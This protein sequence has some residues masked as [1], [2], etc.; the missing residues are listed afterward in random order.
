MGAFF[1][2]H[3]VR[4]QSPS[5]VA[6]AVAKVVSGKAYVSPESGGWVSVYAEDSET[7]AEDILT[8]IAEGLSKLLKT[9]VIGFLVHDSDIAAYWLYQSGKLADQFNSCPDYFG[10]DIDEKTRQSLRGNTD[11]L[12]PLCL[13][14]TPRDNLDSLLHSSDDEP[15]FA[16][17]ILSE[18]AAFLGIDAQRITAGHGIFE[19]EGVELFEDADQFI[20]VSGKA[21][22]KKRNSKTNEAPEKVPDPAVVSIVLLTM[23]WIANVEGLKEYEFA[24]LGGISRQQLESSFENAAKE[25][26]ELSGLSDRPS[27]EELVAA[28]D[29]GPEALASFIAMRFPQLLPDVGVGAVNKLLEEFVTALLK[30]GLNPMSVDYEGTSTMQAAEFFGKDSSIYKLVKAAVEKRA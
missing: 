6:E 25:S 24:H 12:L 2:N 8:H 4:S 30:N 11:L 14:D 21:K 26:L 28:R 5:D 7:Q 27:F 18:L 10:E 20:H 29:Q 15:T 9:H 16:E 1:T 23:R 17:E 13:A 19:Q 22:P 3:Q